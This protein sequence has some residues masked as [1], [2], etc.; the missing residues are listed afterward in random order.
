MDMLFRKP[1]RIKNTNTM[2][3]LCRAWEGAETVMIGAGAGV[4]TAAGFTYSGERFDKYFKDFGDKYHFNNMYAGGFYS[5]ETLNE[6]W[7]YWSRYIYINRYMDPP[8]PLYEEIYRLVKD[9]DYFVITTNVGC[10]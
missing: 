2:E 6:Y 10:I 1:E 4:S 9:K 3:K 8:K 5:Y 7:A